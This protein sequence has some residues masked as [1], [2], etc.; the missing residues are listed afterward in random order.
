M[1]NIRKARKLASQADTCAKRCMWYLILSMAA[2]IDA[3]VLFF[4]DTKSG[5]FF[6]LSWILAAIGGFAAAIGFAECAGGSILLAILS[7][8]AGVAMLREN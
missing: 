2:L 6:V 4:K 7:I 3:A 1:E 5:H 8:T